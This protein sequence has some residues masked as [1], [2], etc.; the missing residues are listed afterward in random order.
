MLYN[1][2]VPQCSP[3]QEAR[4]GRSEDESDVARIRGRRSIAWEK[5]GGPSGLIQS[6]I[7]SLI[8]VSVQSVFGIGAGSTIAI[9]AALLILIARRIRRLTIRPAIG[10]VVG[11]VIS[12]VIAYRTGDARDY[13]LPDIWGY[14]ICAVVLAVSVLVRWPL[15][16]VVWSA[17]NGTSMQWR[18]DRK[19][20][21][22]YSIATATAVV[23]FVLR[24]ATLLWFY[25][26]GEAGA[27][28]L[29]RVVVSYPM[30]A[31][32]GVVSAWSIR[33]AEERT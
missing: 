17:L 26:Q 32:V 11:V 21:T 29:M 31:V 5:V 12:S 27:M 4:P 22:G 10:G 2:Y 18:T 1:G 20:R 9:A 6:A 3:T 19:A 7:P 15:A 33:R 8:F 25:R 24:A 14:A 23:A 16:G 13:F 28:A 30:W